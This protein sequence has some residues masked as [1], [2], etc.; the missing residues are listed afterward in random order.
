[1]LVDRLSPS[2]NRIWFWWSWACHGCRRIDCGMTTGANARFP[3]PKNQWIS[4][5]T[6]LCV[7]YTWFR[8]RF[9]DFKLKCVIFHRNCVQVA[10]L[11]IFGRCKIAI[12]STIF[13]RIVIVCSNTFCSISVCFNILAIYIFCCCSRAFYSAIGAIYSCEAH[14]RTFP[15]IRIYMNFQ[16]P[17]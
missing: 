15:L 17:G 14:F 1:M 7:P 3:K 5:I 12:K 9:V 8:C 6:T 16:N 10:V 11:N 4:I 2:C 13:K